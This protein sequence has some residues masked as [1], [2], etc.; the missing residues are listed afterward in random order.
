MTATTTD[1]LTDRR[2]GIQYRFPVGAGKTIHTGTLVVLAA[3]AAEEG[4]TAKSLTAVG[5]AEDHADNSG[6][7]A[8]DIRVPVRRGV[9]AFANSADTDAITLAEV[10][11]D[12]YIVDNQTVAK[13]N[14][15]STR[16]KAGVVRD[17]DDAGVWVE[18]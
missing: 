9:F 1:R 14:S 18:I 10:G 12:C 11:T 6:G 8:G 15:S 16:S 13:T 17:V 5:V 4:S 2:D 7:S 3:G